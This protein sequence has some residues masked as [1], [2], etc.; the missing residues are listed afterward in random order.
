M[1]GFER[2]CRAVI[3]SV[4]AL[5]RRPGRF[6]A[7]AGDARCRARQPHLARAADALQT[8]HRVDQSAAHVRRQIDL[9]RVAGNDDF[10]V[11][12]HARQKHLH[13][14]D[15]R[16][17]RFVENDERI[18]QRPAAHVG[19]RNHLDQIL[20]GVA[21]NLV[22]I[23][24]LAQGIQQRPQV[25]IDFRLQVARQKAQ[26]FAGFDRRPHQHDFPNQLLLQRGRRHRHGQIGFARAGR[27]DAQNQVVLGDRLDVFGLARRPRPNLPAGLQHECRDDC[28][29][30]ARR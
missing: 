18:V 29:A 20:L 22:V 15:G 1:N 23:H 17:L 3:S 13:L 5:R 8:S 27:A 19:Q 10:R 21:A 9:R 26:A 28:S 2:V 11:H 24:H 30:A 12:A 7:P 6:P 16:V 25:R 4:L 14:R